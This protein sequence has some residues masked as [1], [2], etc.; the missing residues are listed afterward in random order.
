MYVVSD[1]GS[2]RVTQIGFLSLF[3][4][5]FAAQRFIGCGSGFESL[6]E[7]MSGFEILAHCAIWS[8]S[9]RPIV[10]GNG[11]LN[12]FETVLHHDHHLPRTH[13]GLR[14]SSRSTRHS[15]LDGELDSFAINLCALK[16]IERLVQ[17]ITCDKA[18]LATT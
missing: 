18:C 1:V 7:S 6:Y 13:S 3:W 10:N 5:F 17:V 9:V 2:V 14:S 16:R 4:R 11:R 12:G 15:Y 8:G